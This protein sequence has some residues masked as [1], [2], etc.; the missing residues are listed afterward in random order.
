MKQKYYVNQLAQ[1]NRDHEVHVEG[2]AWL[3]TPLN[4]QY[5]GEYETCY[6][7]VRE[8]AK[9]IKQVNGC[10]FCCRACHTQ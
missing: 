6:G 8:A 7:A 10:I 3:P 4:R 1:A 5:L 2:C 9:T